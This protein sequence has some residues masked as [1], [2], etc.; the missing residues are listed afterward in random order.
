MLGA[1]PPVP[2]ASSRTNTTVPSPLRVPLGCIQSEACPSNSGHF[3]HVL[4]P[5][6]SLRCSHEPIS[7]P[8]PVPD[9]TILYLY[10][11]SSNIIHLQITW[12]FLVVS[13]FWIC[14]PS[15]ALLFSS[16]RAT[17]PHRLLLELTV[18]VTFGGENILCTF[19]HPPIAS[20]L[21]GAHPRL[22]PFMC[23][24]H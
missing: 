13:F 11:P 12:V 17:C 8:H 14:K 5:A 23:D 4:E 15:C 9:V 16:V 10:Y 2:H 19:L 7:G 22:C 6:G 21:I 24:L 3:Q 20:T 18:P 1:M